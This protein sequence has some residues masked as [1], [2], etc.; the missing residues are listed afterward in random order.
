MVHATTWMKHENL[1]LMKK[2][3]RQYLFPFRIDEFRETKRGGKVV[4][5][6][7]GV[8]KGISGCQGLL[9]GKNE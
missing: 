7:E 6:C 8:R 4:R 5:G 1:M 3:S 2:T 9:G